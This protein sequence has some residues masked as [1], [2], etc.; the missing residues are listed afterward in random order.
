MASVVL[1]PRLKWRYFEDN[2]I[3]TI[4]LARHIG[5]SKTKLRRL[6][7]NKYKRAEVGPSLSQS[8]EPEP[9]TSF[10]EDILNRVAPTRET[11]VPTPTAT[12][13]QLFLYLEEPQNTE[14][15]LLTYWQKREAKWPQLAQMAYDFLAIP[16]MSS[17][18]ERVFSSTAKQTTPESSRLSG[19]LL[20]HQE[21]ISNWQRRGAVRIELAFNAVLLNLD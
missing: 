3:G 4:G 11:V 5:P 9:Q 10:F 17:E 15:G 12:R 14:Y 19:E 16:A 20:W 13:D 21:C 18:C 2:W 1:H 6:W 8:P 7:E